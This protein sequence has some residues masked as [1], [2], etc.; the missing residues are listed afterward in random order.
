MTD[1]FLL[2]VQMRGAVDRI[3]HRHDPVQPIGRGSDRVGHQRRQD[4]NW[5]G[6]AGRFYDNPANIAA[7]TAQGFHV[8]RFEDPAHLNPLLIGYGLLEARGAEG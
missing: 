2:L 1:G 6:Q 5:I 7:A 3:D 4:G 8:H